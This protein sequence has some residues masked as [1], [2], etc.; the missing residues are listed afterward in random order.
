L[1]MRLDGRPGLVTYTLAKRGA[2]L[3]IVREGEK[4][5]KV[6]DY[7]REAWRKAAK[8]GRIFAPVAVPA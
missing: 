1:L 8:E 2:L 4:G 6:K 3:C 7:H 5:R